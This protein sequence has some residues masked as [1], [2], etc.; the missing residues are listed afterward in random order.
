MSSYDPRE[1]SQQVPCV[2]NMRLC[3]GGTLL[4]RDYGARLGVG[5]LHCREGFLIR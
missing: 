5:D 1:R 2:P 4:H 3:D